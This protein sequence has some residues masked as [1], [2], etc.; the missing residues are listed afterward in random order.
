MTTTD[1]DLQYDGELTDDEPL[2]VAI[3]S[4]GWRAFLLAVVEIL[5]SHDVWADGSD[6]AAIDEQMSD[7][8]ARLMGVDAMTVLPYP[9]VLSWP[10]YALRW[11]SA[12][13]KTLLILTAQYGNA[14]HRQTTPMNEEPVLYIA[15]ILEAGSYVLGLI[16]VKNNNA[17][18]AR[19]YVDNQYL[20]AA[21]DFDM[22]A[23]SLTYNFVVE[24]PITLATT[25][26]HTFQLITH[27][28]H[29]SSS[30]YFL[31]VSGVY[32]IRQ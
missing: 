4:N 22:Y 6:F 31:F 25:G 5:A 29:A 15:E 12:G 26:R 3:Y 10:S 1:G 20:D 9:E 21:Y 23:A 30:N 24:V 11:T 27:G 7:L 14:S 32:L 19:W 17:G 16:G 8:A 13:G 18:K 2:T 28:K